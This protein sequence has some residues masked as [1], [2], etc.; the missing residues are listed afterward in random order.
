MKE[1]V[2]WTMGMMIPL[3]PHPSFGL[4]MNWLRYDIGKWL[5]NYMGVPHMFPDVKMKGWK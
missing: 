2:K 4:T 1:S 3:P 5:N